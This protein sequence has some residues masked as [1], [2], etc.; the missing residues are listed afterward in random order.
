MRGSARVF[1][2]QSLTQ[3]QFRASPRSTFKHHR[4]PWRAGNLVEHRQ[5]IAFA[6]KFRFQIE[7]K[8]QAA[9]GFVGIDLSGH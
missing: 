9:A 2:I 8:I 7:V 6:R 5:R 4:V 3:F 1:S